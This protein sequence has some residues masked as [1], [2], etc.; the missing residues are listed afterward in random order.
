M[1]LPTPYYSRDG[2]VI[3][4][5]DALDVLPQLTGLDA[6]IVDP[7]YSSGGAFR[8][9]RMGSTV[10]KYVQSGTTA[11]RSEFAGDNRDQRGYLAWCSLWLTAAL[12]ASNPSAVVACFSDWR[13]LPTMT[14]A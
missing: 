2:I 13:Q 12:H 4:C 14:D 10:S 7:P 9:D 6:L 1:S 3:Y 8:V 11:V 5:G